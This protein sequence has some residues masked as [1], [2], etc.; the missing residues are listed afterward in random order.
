MIGPELSRIGSTRTRRDLL[1]AILYP[2]VRL[3]QSY[4]PLRVLTQD[5]QVYNGLVKS[6]NAQE[7]VLI[8]AAERPS[9]FH[10]MRSMFD[11]RATCRSCRWTRSNVESPRI[12]RFDRHVGNEEV[13][14]ALGVCRRCFGPL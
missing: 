11:K 3:A 14:D 5:G 1:E 9:L 13:K 12:G 6:E 2:S 8:L 4:Q 7:L 10:W